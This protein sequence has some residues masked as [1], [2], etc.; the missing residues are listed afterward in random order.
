MQL[1]RT[2]VQGFAVSYGVLDGLVLG[3]QRQSVVSVTEV[4]QAVPWPGNHAPVSSRRTRVLRMVSTIGEMT[5]LG[6]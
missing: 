3:T 6:V 4:A 1:R 5:F 2:D